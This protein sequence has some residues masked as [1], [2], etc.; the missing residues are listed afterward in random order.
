MLGSVIPLPDLNFLRMIMS[1]EIGSTP[2]VE[3]NPSALVDNSY[4]PILHSIFH[5]LP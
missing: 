4:Y 1:V 3:W 2:V 5:I